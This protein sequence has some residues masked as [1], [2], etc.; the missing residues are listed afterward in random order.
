MKTSPST[1]ATTGRLR[2]RLVSSLLTLTVLGG[3]I[4][5]TAR[6]AYAATSVSGC[7]RTAQGFAA[8]PGYPVHLAV[9]VGNT[10]KY[11][12]YKMDQN[13]CVQIATHPWAN[14]YKMLVVNTGGALG[15]YVGGGTFYGQSPLMAGPGSGH[16][17]LGLGFLYYS[18]EG[19]VNAC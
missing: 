14:Y 16:L 6:P 13:G 12:P 18:C 4:V 2:R 8:L 17:E 3:T 9:Y 1:P 11:Y 7:F 5:G 15:I 10:W 19:R